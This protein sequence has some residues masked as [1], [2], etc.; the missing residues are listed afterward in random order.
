MRWRL[1][2]GWTTIREAIEIQFI[3]TRLRK[4]EAL[5]PTRIILET[6][7]DGQVQ[8]M[9]AQQFVEAGHDFL[10]AR[11]VAGNSLADAKLLLDTFPSCI[12]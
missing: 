9:T 2:Q 10:Q 7:V 11:I 5:K 12:T 6:I 4:L 1:R 8:R 3:D